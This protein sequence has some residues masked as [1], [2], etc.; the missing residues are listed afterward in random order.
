[1]NLVE[2][3]GVRGKVFVDSDDLIDLDKLFDV[4]AQDCDVIVL[5]WS[6]QVLNRPWCVGELV[7]AKSNKVPTVPILFAAT[8]VP[9]EDFVI[10]FKQHCPDIN[11]LF[12]LG[13]NIALCQ[14]TITWV[15]GLPGIRLPQELSQLVIQKFCSGVLVPMKLRVSGHVEVDSMPDIPSFELQVVIIADSTNFEAT[16]AQLILTK[17]IMPLCS[18]E[19]TRLPFG[20]RVGASLPQTASDLLLLCTVGVLQQPQV[21]KL[22]GEVVERP[23]ELSICPVVVDAGFIFPSPSS[24]QDQFLLAKSV[25]KDDV[26]VPEMIHLIREIFK[27]IA[28]YFQPHSTNDKTIIQRATEVFGR[29]QMKDIRRHSSK[30]QASKSEGELSNLEVSSK[31]SFIR[32]DE[33]SEIQ[34]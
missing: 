4:V 33:E 23:G 3:R 34:I 18:H 21:L 10:N 13:I 22:L 16:S 27:G 26:N 14:E 9:V 29:V 19:P 1:M 24:L 7:T 31:R 8:I 6:D 30:G 5:V 2:L 12:A 17:L 25:G 32:E 11:C 28:V 20:L 15:L